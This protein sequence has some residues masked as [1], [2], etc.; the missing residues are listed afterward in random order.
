MERCQIGKGLWVKNYPSWFIRREFE[1][2][3]SVKLLAIIPCSLFDK[4][5][6][7]H[8]ERL[9]QYSL[10]N[11]AILEQLTVW[12]DQI[13]AIKWRVSY[14]EVRRGVQPPRGNLTNAQAVEVIRNCLEGLYYVV[15]RDWTCR[16]IQVGQDGDLKVC[17]HSED[18]VAELISPLLQLRDMS[19][20]L[21]DNDGFFD[22]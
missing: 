2:D 14:K 18:S 20:R 4:Q 21:I 5:N 1:L 3:R 10:E 9:R 7:A 16:F 12:L 11:A 13:G 15:L 6:L 22:L 17:L 19:P 8:E